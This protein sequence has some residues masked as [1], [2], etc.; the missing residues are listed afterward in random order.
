MVA[1]MGGSGCGGMEQDEAEVAW[2]V[3]VGREMRADLTRCGSLG[4]TGAM[5]ER[6]GR[7]RITERAVK[8][9]ERFARET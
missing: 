9:G 1:V 4:K 7:A 6:G 8:R 5:T 3:G 2:E